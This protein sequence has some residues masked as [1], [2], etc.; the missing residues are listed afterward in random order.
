MFPNI[1]TS[2]HVLNQKV[3]FQ[4]IHNLSVDRM[5]HWVPIER[6]HPR[7]GAFGYNVEFFIKL[8]S[9]NSYS[10]E[11]LYVETSFKYWKLLCCDLRKTSSTASGFSWGPDLFLTANSEGSFGVDFR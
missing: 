4:N 1:G 11:K 6:F 5:V 8:A 10:I 7:H 3:C 9:L 2:E